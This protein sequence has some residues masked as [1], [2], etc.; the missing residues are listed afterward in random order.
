MY[1]GVSPLQALVKKEADARSEWIDSTIL[2]SIPSWKGGLI[3]KYKSRLL[4]RILGVNVEIRHE[5]LISDFGTRTVIL[6]NGKAIGERK[7]TGTYKI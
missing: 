6:L 4:A 3:K 5:E 1:T 2:N 7:Y